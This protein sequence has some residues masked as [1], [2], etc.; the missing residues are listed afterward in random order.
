MNSRLDMLIHLLVVFF[1]KNVVKALGLQVGWVP[2]YVGEV[3]LS[4]IFGTRNI[5]YQ[6]RA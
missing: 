3:N 5:F 1:G 4:T 6:K 2:N